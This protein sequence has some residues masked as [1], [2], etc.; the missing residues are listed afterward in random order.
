MSRFRRT[1]WNPA[2]TFQ[3]RRYTPDAGF[4][5]VDTFTYDPGAS[6]LIL[7]KMVGTTNHLTSDD[8]LFNAA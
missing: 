5:G 1:P 8:Y 3:P 4:T 7:V 6:R 2:R